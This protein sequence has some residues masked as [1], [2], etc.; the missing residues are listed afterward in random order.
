MKCKLCGAF[1][2]DA[3]GEQRQAAYHAETAR[4]DKA[5]AGCAAWSSAVREFV[6]WR[7]HYQ[8]PEEVEHEGDQFEKAVEG[9]NEMLKQPHPGQRYLEL[10]QIVEG[11]PKLEEA[12]IEQL[13][14][15][16][17][18]QGYTVEF[19]HALTRLLAWRSQ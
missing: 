3:E 7:L 16:L 1:P 10:A 6:Y 15:V 14:Q 5:E 18:L 11:L 17:R 13:K 8:S 9:L 2:L 19:T 4:A 12:R